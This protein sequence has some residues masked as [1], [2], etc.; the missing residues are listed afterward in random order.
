MIRKRDLERVVK[1]AMLSRE[2]SDHEALER[3]GYDPHAVEA[4][5]LEIADSRAMH[6]IDRRDAIAAA[7]AAGLELAVRV[8]RERRGS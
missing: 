3:L 4:M 6:A 2:S 7:F 1:R 5:G 8:E